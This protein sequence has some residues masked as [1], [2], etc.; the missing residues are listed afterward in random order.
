MDK[1][2]DAAATAF[3]EWNDSMAPLYMIGVCLLVV[4]LVLLVKPKDYR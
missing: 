1:F 2:L 4:F 3:N